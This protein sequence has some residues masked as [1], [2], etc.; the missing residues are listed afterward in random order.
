MSN[1]MMGGTRTDGSTWAFYETNGCG[2]GARPNADGID[3]IQCHMT[4]TLN[5]PIEAIERDYP[6]RVVRY[7]FAEGTG[8]AGHFRGGNGLIRAFTLTEGDA[9]VTLLAERHAVHPPG[10][11]GGAPGS[12]GKHERIRTNGEREMLAAKGTLT[13]A[14]GETMVVQ[15]PGGG[16][17]GHA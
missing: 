2:M 10:A 17:F 7:E 5:T 16:G 12:P 1:V 3:G 4:N 15:T 8:G 9:Q 6:L 14:S 13:L 11:Q